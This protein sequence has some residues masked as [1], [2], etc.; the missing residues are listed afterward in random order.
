MADETPIGADDVARKQF[1]TAFRGFDQNEVRAFLAQL[2]AELGSLHER[3]RALRERLATAEEKPAPRGPVGEDELEAALGV[4]TTRVLHAAREA[5]AE[6]RAKA[7]ESVGRML[8]EVNDETSRMKT[9]AETILGRRTEEAEAASSAILSA[10]EETAAIVRADAEAS[11]LATIEEAQQRGREMLAEAQAVRERVLKDLARRRKAAAAQLEQL[12]AG[13]Q[14]LLSA[15]DVVR[16]TL[17]EATHELT[18][19]EHEARQAA[20][21]A[22]LRASADDELSLVHEPEPEP[23]PD[24]L[25]VEPQPDPRPDPSPEPEPETE[26]VPESRREPQPDPEPEPNVIKEPQAA[27]RPVAIV[28]SPA[29]V[30][31]PGDTTDDRRS[32]SL[33]LLRRKGEAPEVPLLDEVD[34]VR[35]IRPEAAPSSRPMVVPDLPEQP[36]SE[37]EPLATE[38]KP[39]DD[40]FARLRADRAAA[41]AHAEEVLTAAPEVDASEEPAAEPV[42]VEDAVFEQRDAALETAE[43]ALT[44]ALKRALADEQNEV[45]DALR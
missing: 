38:E 37:P 34:G 18:V 31:E 41:V 1:A 40:L 39:V 24:P 14:R 16:G 12:L 7:E 43:R 3:E 6:I 21:A 11:A 4:E 10:A 22:G 13:R 17:D 36:E 25:A 42:V 35:V 44:R 2:A 5:A 28:P 23:E 29:E 30:P 20:E 9:E 8:R 19:A 32:S 27:A 33:R 26:S 45:L 15:Y